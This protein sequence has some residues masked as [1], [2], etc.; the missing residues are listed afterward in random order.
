VSTQDDYLELFFSQSLDGFF[1]MMIDEP[2]RWDDSVD[3]E[4]ALDYVFEHQR[5]TKVN[6][7]LLAQYGATREQ[8]LGRRPCDLF[9]HDLA[10]GRE[11]WRRF[12]DAGR[13]H[14]ETDERRYDGTPIW[15][16]GDYICFHDGEGRITGHFG[17]QRDVSDRK[18]AEVALR[19]S[20]RR[21]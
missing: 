14:V 1:F 7:A 4:A 19:S 12:F 18:Q 16:E 2:V 10:Y 21:L 15:I 9:E 8:F 13:L 3:K 11:I 6:D 5:M 20:N 17:I